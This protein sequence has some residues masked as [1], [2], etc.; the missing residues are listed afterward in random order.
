M[1]LRVKDPIVKPQQGAYDA[2]KTRL[3]RSFNLSQ[4]ERGS[5]ILDCPELGNRKVTKMADEL[6]NFCEEDRAD[7]LMQEIFL[8]RLPSRFK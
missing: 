7:L 3:L 6:M 8:C 4:K 2:L 5:R 1:A